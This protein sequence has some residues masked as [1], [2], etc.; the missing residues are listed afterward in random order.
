MKTITKLNNNYYI[1]FVDNTDKLPIELVN[2]KNINIIN[3]LQ[4]KK[5]I[6]K[7]DFNEFSKKDYKKILKNLL[8]QK[9]VATF[10]KKELGSNENENN[11][12]AYI[13]NFDNNNVEQ[14]NFIS[15]LNAI[16]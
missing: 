14:K 7:I 2:I 15:A 16:F 9:Q 13:S 11:V 5:I 3:I 1:E 8:F 4:R 10:F 6:L 12:V